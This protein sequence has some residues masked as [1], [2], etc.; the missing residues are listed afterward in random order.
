MEAFEFNGS[1]S[2][3]VFGIGTLKNSLPK[4]VARQNL[5]APLILSTP[6]QE[7]WTKLIELLLDGKAVGVFNEAIIHT[8]IHITEK[9]LGYLKDNNADSIISI[10]GGS[11]IGLG[12]ALAVRTGLY[13]MCLPTTYSGT[14]MTSLLGETKDGVKKTR[15]DLKILP[16]TVI[17]DVELTMSLPPS[18]TATSGVNAMAHAGRL[19]GLLVSTKTRP[20]L[21]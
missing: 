19:K 6:R 10:G 3:V 13:H 8:P 17:Y 12:K 18:L 5:K 1:P 16:G 14:E 2:R 21:V 4:E 11:T 15:T 7:E 20:I 9:A